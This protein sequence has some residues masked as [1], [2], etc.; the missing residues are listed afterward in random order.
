MRCTKE[1]Y[2]YILKLYNPFFR[3]DER[4]MLLMAFC[5]R[6]YITM[7]IKTQAW[8]TKEIEALK[9]RFEGIVFLKYSVDD[10]EYVE[11]WNQLWNWTNRDL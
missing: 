5:G 4:A 9:K 6:L 1:I 7:S 3:F 11:L 8:K 10:L 2:D